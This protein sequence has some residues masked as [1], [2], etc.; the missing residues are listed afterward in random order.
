MAL[1]ALVASA[2]V[3]TS[4]PFASAQGP[5]PLVRSPSLAA[6]NVVAGSSADGV[7]PS[8]QQVQFQVAL[9][10]SNPTGIHRLLAQLNDPSSPEYHHW[11]KPGQF[12]TTF[13][14]STASVSAVESW[15][16]G[17]GITDIH[18]SGF[19]VTASATAATVTS[20]L[21]TP[22][23][24][25]RSRSGKV[26]FST[27]EA[28]LVP[29]NLAGST[30]Q[31]IVGLDNAPAFQSNLVP[32]SPSTSGSATGQSGTTAGSGSTGQPGSTGAQ[33]NAGE[34]S[35]TSAT[36]PPNSY[37]DSLQELS[38]DYG[39]TSLQADG[40][41]GANEAI[42]VY[43]LGAS[44]STDYDNYEGCYGLT[45][46]VQVVPV[47]GG[48]T[49]GTSVEANADIEQV[50][51]QAPNAL[52]ISY[53]GPN[54]AQGAYDTWYTI[55]NDDAAQVVSTSWGEC[56]DYAA[57][58]EALFEQAATQG[59]S[60]VAAS[61]DSG[62]EDCYRD[63][64]P[65]TEEALEVDYPASDPY[66]TGVGGTTLTSNNETVWNSCNLT[67]RPGCYTSANGQASGG[68]GFSLYLARPTYQPNVTGGGIC[69]GTTCRE[70]PDLSA[71]AGTGM[72]VYS[73]GNWGGVAGTSLSAPLVAGLL[74]DKNDGCSTSTG[75]FNPDLYSLYNAG[76][77]GTALRDIT[78]GNNDMT[79]LNGGDYGSGTGY[80]LATGVGSPIAQGLSCPEITSISPSTA[81]A[82]STVTLTGLGLEKANIS[83]GG[84]TA[85]VVGTPTATS[86]TVTVPA[87]SGTVSVVG[88]S[89]LGTGTTDGSFTFG[90][91]SSTTTTTS[92]TS[93]TVPT[94]TT[95]TTPA[96]TTTTA[97]PVAVA[98]PPTPACSTAAGAHLGS[99]V[100]IA[101]TV[102]DG[103]KGYWV[104][105]AAGQVSAFGAAAFH[106]DLSGDHLNAP[107]ISITATAD[108]G[109]YWLLGAD[110][111]VFAFG[112]AVFHGS[113]GGIHLNASVVGMAVTADG[114]GYWIIAKDGGVFSFGDAKFYG[115]TGGL[116]LNEPVDG[117]AV[118]PG[119][120]GYWLVASDGGVFTFTPDGFYGSLG[121]KHLNKPIVGMA[122][123]PDGHGY[124][125]VAADGG[126]FT[127]GDA[128]FYGSLGANPPSTP[129]VDLSPTPDNGGYT[130]VDA[131]GQVFSFGD[132]A[133][134]GSAG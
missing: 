33:S 106:G 96:T 117:L 120:N 87:G 59:Q 125:L 119:G 31:S 46:A 100:G 74:A 26:T 97:A 63:S 102:V 18:F 108:G 134:Y 79:G 111:G 2:L 54:S 15:L 56:E 124:T 50:A 62:S 52:V 53:E 32:V 98:S 28:P 89:V 114:A 13:G 94:T 129:V 10:P 110:G 25:Y 12:E 45:N 126:V 77:Y 132:A 85:T 43:E 107:I 92:T 76:V 84:N 35:N 109:G 16:R 105:D 57:S 23:H 80:D 88:T 49:G 91:S 17:R 65:A 36:C 42:G 104:V 37:F 6:P 29:Q 66:V 22:F 67:N 127:Y 131:A 30:V 61:G 1:A 40:E 83:F 9:A 99:A 34:Q 73:G 47:D 72:W 122:G 41:S 60:I 64:V 116:K 68:G 93:T 130:L 81:T 3:A 14:P 112:D 48:A 38:A 133:N 78:S 11:L 121:G 69:A 115:S 123:T 55:V 19:A 20:A 75:L 39:I 71:N 70:V 103:C 101:N 7:L 58:Y 118:A 113:T 86:A 44:S 21:G 82:G 95:T 5:S 8:T 4:G 90:S 51:T 128:S 24:R 27:T